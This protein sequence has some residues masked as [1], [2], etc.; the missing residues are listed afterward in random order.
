[1][2]FISNSQKLETSQTSNICGMSKY[3]V[4]Y[5]HNGTLHSNKKENLLIHT[6]QVKLTT[7][8]R[9]CYLYEVQTQARAIEVD[10]GQDNCYPWE[11]E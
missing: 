8:V 9:I 11:R 5:P 4:V 7:E 6:A 1:M 2:S 3:V 10:S